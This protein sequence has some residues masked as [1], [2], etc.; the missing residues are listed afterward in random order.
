MKELKI[1]SQALPVIDVN[2]EEVKK[3]LQE[4]LEQYKSLVV[5]EGSLNLCKANQK[6]LAGLK[7]KVDTY[8]KD[9]KKTMSEPI[10]VFES[11]CKELVSLIESAEQPL[12]D[13]IKVFDDKK[14]EE[15][16]SIALNIISEIVI[17]HGISPKYA[18][19]LTVLDKYTNLT[20]MES[21]V[22]E[23][24]EQRAFILL[25]EQKKELELLE[26]IQD[27]IDTANKRIKRQLTFS[28]FQRYIDN[29]MST[30]DVIQA[31]NANADRI[32]EAEN[33]PPVE[34]EPTIEPITETYLWKSEPQPVVEHSIEQ[35]TP[36]IK[37][38]IQTDLTWVVTMKITATTSQFSLLKQ[39]LLEN[40]ITYGVSNK[41]LIG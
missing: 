37:Q 4:Q 39:F 14:R 18:N 8:R 16:R 6:A 15:K 1:I 9:V 21:E 5:T 34:P 35:P 27:A 26:L 7:G 23:D 24:I 20:A 12:K 41:E 28:E 19:Q 31:I 30:K 2:F 22:R 3:D 17:K 13:G 29:G 10:T 36:V 40:K 11:K 25:G 38:P 32:Y 33:P